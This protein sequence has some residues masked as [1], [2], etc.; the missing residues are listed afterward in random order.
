MFYGNQLDHFH[1]QYI[2][3]SATFASTLTSV[4]NPTTLTSHLIGTA[5]TSISNPSTLTSAPHSLQL[6]T[7]ISST[8]TFAPYSLDMVAATLTSTLFFVSL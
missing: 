3:T 2:L 4:S 8:L 6:H 7:H 1:T 5:L